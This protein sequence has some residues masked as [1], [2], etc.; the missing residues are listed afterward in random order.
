NSRRVAFHEYLQQNARKQLDA[1][2]ARARALGMPIGL[3]VDLALGAD[4]G[5]AEVW[6]DQSAFALD[7]SCGA[8]P[9]EFNPR[10]QDWGLPPFSPRALRASGCAQFG[11]L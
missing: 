9:D 6:A 7:V 4:A 11:A 8:P 3:Y 10:G 5:G 2:Q 1:A